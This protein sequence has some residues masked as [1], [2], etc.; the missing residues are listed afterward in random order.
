MTDIVML[1]GDPLANVTNLLD[2]PM[3]IKGGEVLFE[4]RAAGPARR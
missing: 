2:V 1:N 3:T 4:K